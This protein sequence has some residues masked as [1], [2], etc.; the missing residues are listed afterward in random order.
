[1]K[2]H[3]H[4]ELDFEPVFA[5][6]RIPS[7]LTEEGFTRKSNKSFGDRRFSK[8]GF[9]DN[10][11]AGIRQRMPTNYIDESE[12]FSRLRGS[13]LLAAAAVACDDE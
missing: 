6:R 8:R 10:E 11:E 9:D 7:Q 5:R 12:K 3:H 13:R 2:K 1:M 4:V